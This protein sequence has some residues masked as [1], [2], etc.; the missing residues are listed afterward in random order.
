MFGGYYNTSVRVL[1]V[2]VWSIPFSLLRAVPVVALV[3]RGREDQ[4]LRT[5]AW[6]AG[7]NVVLNVG[8]IPPY[9]M[10]GAAVA[11]M[12]TE[13][14]RLALAAACARAEGFRMPGMV[15]FWRTT[16]AA[17]IMF[18]LLSLVQPLPLWLGV[19]LGILTYV[20]ALALLG[21][22]RLHRSALPEL[23]V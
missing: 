1:Q 22:M 16:V 15:R 4:V 2:L 9:G 5:T 18:T 7:L 11:T 17:L 6:A 10:A 13:V 3:A 14:V 19:G 20:F 12:M 21:G 8:L 23:T